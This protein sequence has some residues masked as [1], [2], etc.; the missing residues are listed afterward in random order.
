[1]PYFDLFSAKDAEDMLKAAVANSQINWI[2]SDQDVKSFL[3]KLIDAK[4]K[5]LDPD[6][7]KEVATLIAEDGSDPDEDIPF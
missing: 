2:A 3:E 6:I 5:E 7:V 1:M 4:G